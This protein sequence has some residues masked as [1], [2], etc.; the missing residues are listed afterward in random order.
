[1]M[2]DKPLQEY[3]FIHDYYFMAGDNISIS[4]DSRY[5]GFVPDVFIVGKAYCLIGHTSK[6]TREGKK[7]FKKI[8]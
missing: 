2:N 1:M 8:E 7:W 4:V 3:T 5:W 6:N